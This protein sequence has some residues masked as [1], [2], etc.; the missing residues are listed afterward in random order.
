[1]K[2][3][4][5]KS[6]ALACFFSLF[7]MVIAQANFETGQICRASCSGTGENQVCTFKF[8]MDIFAGETGYYRVEG[9]DG[10]QPTLYMEENVTYIFNQSHAT[11]WFHPLGFAYGPDGVYAENDE[12]EKGVVPPGGTFC[13]ESTPC[14]YPQYKLN[15][16][17]LCSSE[18]CEAGDFG[19]DEYEGVWFSGGRDDWIDAGDFSVEV[20]ITDPATTELFYFC[21]I[22]NKM[23][24]RI[25]VIDSNGDPK[26]PNDIVPLTYDYNEISAFD[27]DCGT[28]NISRYED[29]G[30]ECPEMTFICNDNGDFNKCMSAIDCA[31][32]VEMRVSGTKDPTVT[33]MHQMIAHHRNAVN[34]AKILLKE[35]PTSLKCG[36]S[37]DGRRLEG[38]LHE[39]CNDGN[40]DGGTPAVTLLWEIINVQNAQITFMN[41]WLK[42]NEQVSHDFCEHETDNT[43]VIALGVATGIMFF[44]GMGLTVLLTKMGYCKSITKNEE[45]NQKL[46]KEKNDQGTSSFNNQA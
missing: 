42:D 31:M 45:L 27:E 43:A 30:S 36:T 35:N 38:D 10:I 14:Q 12:L 19:L 20:K 16:E 25:K 5:L 1:M 18:P 8:E 32:H 28:H 41:A 13:N 11:N 17:N 22:H 23:S 37:Y 2:G 4:I 6:S 29:Y 46:V 39:F 3:Q 33:F 34:M 7:K 9:C 44:L 21:H 15:G 24:G 40:N 26:N